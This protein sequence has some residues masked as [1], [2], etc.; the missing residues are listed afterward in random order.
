MEEASFQGLEQVS[1]GFATGRYFDS[2]AL[3]PLLVHEGIYFALFVV[4][5]IGHISSPLLS[6]R[7]KG[8]S[9]LVKLV[10]AGTLSAMGSVPGP[11]FHNIGLVIA[12][13]SE[14]GQI[15]VEKNMSRI[16]GRHLRW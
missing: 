4:E 12:G 2:G 13:G 1:N 6:F 15:G 7:A 5:I 11:C 14:V 9:Q 3:P 16:E 10:W 8:S